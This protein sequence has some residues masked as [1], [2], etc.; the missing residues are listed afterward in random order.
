MKKHQASVGKNQKQKDEEDVKRKN[1]IEE[2]K[3]HERVSITLAQ[4]QELAFNNSRITEL[5]RNYERSMAKH[6][7]SLPLAPREKVDNAKLLREMLQSNSYYLAYDEDGKLIHDESAINN[8]AVMNSTD[9]LDETLVNSLRESLL[10]AARFGIYQDESTLSFQG[11]SSS[12]L[13]KNII[14]NLHTNHHPNLNIQ[15]DGEEDGGGGE[16]IISPNVRKLTRGSSAT[17]ILSITPKNGY[18]SIKSP[19]NNHRNTLIDLPHLFEEDSQFTTQELKSK[20]GGNTFKSIYQTRLNEHVSEA[21][22]GKETPLEGD[23]GAFNKSIEQQVE[24][25]KIKMENKRLLVASKEEETKVIV[26]PKGIIGGVSL[27]VGH[28]RIT[29]RG[30]IEDIENQSINVLKRAQLK[31]TDSKREVLMK[32]N[33]A[34]VDIVGGNVGGILG[35][36]KKEVEEEEEGKINDETRIKREIE[37]RARTT[38]NHIKTLIKENDTAGSEYISHLWAL[39]MVKEM[40]REGGVEISGDGSKNLGDIGLN[41]FDYHDKKESYKYTYEELKEMWR[42][43]A[44]KKQKKIKEGGKESEEITRGQ[45]KRMARWEKLW[46]DAKRRQVEDLAKKKRID[47]NK[48]E[49]NIAESNKPKWS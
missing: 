28:R 37:E 18:R 14:V 38:L 39:S 36:E 26:S 1:V 31:K 9:L 2:K 44:L 6:K 34:L 42:L 32:F 33:E 20:T 4:T 29:S 19:K 43:A 35:G 8:D 10:I 45:A 40:Q 49:N 23:K 22:Y 17:S 41:I 46:L 12:S 25:I 13:A 15:V 7:E 30:G 3:R 5:L 48:L 47:L 24:G 27:G 21:L 16:D 11:H